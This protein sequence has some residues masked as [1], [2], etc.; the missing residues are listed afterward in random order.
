MGRV[1]ELDGLRALAILMVV[2][3]HY[4]GM[5]DGSD[6]VPYRLFIF[7]RTGVDLF[8][9]LSGYLITTML[10][11]NKDSPRY[12]PTFYGRRSFRIL[13]IYFVMVT[14]YLVGR[15]VSGSTAN[16][17]FGGSVP[18]WSYLIGAQ[19]VWMAA[20]Q[21]YGAYWLAGT[22]SLAIEEQFYL[23][24]PFVIYFLPSRMLPRLLMALLL[25]CP[26]GRMVA[27]GRG[28]EFGY[29]VLTPLRADILAVG[30]LIAWLEFSGSISP[31]IRR[32][33]KIVFW[34]TASF[35]PIFAWVVDNST[36]NNAVW[37]HTY[38]V[39]FYG[40]MVFMALDNRGAPQLAFLRSRIAAFFARISYAL[41]LIHGPVIVLVLALAG[42]AART[43]LTA[44]GVAL[45]GLAFAI[46]V[47]ICA[48]SYRLIE[49]PLISRAH[50]KFRFEG[51]KPVAAMPVAI[52][53]A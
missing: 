10:L 30:A 20:H 9:V 2:A 21:T 11:A 38:L 19:N 37:G 46:S 31:A 28:D 14:V 15:H 8:F 3:W 44:Q 34:S 23:I 6:S 48:A 36:F 53:H 4:L 51:S 45:A 40:S 25:L 35:F 49:G 13:P 41:Y 43:V 32:I 12:F 16:Y 7:G 33:F 50:R 39:A 42:T 1:K 18:W 29:Y 52:G 47:A 24:F 5:G 27:Y 26:I 22:W 17:L